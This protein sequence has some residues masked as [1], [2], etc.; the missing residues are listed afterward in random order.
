MCVCRCFMLT[1][2]TAL[3]TAL[4]PGS[5]PAR[6]SFRVLTVVGSVSCSMPEMAMA[7]EL[8]PGGGEGSRGMEEEC[9]MGG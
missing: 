1:A 5:G 6:H 9:C 3:A 8:V 7:A 4:A 2:V